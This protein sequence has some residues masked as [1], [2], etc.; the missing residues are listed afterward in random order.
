MEIDVIVSC[1]KNLLKA[2]G[3]AKESIIAYFRDIKQFRNYLDD[4][5]ITDIRDITR[6]IIFS[7]YE[8]VMSQSVAV[9]T[10]ALK[11]RAI[12]RLFEHL[13]EDNKLLLNPTEGLMEPSR[14]NRPIGVVLTI[15]EIKKLL[16]QP[17]LSLKIDIRDRVIMEVLYATGVR[18]NELLSLEVY[19]VDLKDGVIF[20]RKGKGN[21]D[22]VVPL[23]KRVIPLL[24]EYLEKVRPHYVR[25]N[26][27]SRSLFLDRSGRKLSN[28][29]IRAILKKY[30]KKAKITKLVSVHTFRRTCA[31]HLLQQGADIRYVQKLLGHKSLNTTQQYTKVIPIDIKKTHKIT[32][33]NEKIKI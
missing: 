22:R 16:S 33:P 28:M 23:G 26:P 15:T 21:K 25:K 12:K 11:I 18:H 8:K 30:R 19:D 14:K 31:T 10:K 6:N 32:H 9:E 1:F 24:K 20:I 7:Y 4:N 5:N 13:L 29:A 3:Y 17:N 27:R 2:R